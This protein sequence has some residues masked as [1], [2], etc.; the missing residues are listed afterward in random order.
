MFNLKLSASQKPFEVSK[1]SSLV[2]ATFGIRDNT[3]IPITVPENEAAFIHWFATVRPQTDYVNNGRMHCFEGAFR[4]LNDTYH[5]CQRYFNTTEERFHELLRDL[6]RSKS[7]AIFY[8]FDIKRFTILG[9]AYYYHKNE[10]FH[11]YPVVDGLVDLD[12]SGA[13]AKREQEINNFREY[14]K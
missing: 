1:T 14:C 8:C 10:C 11:G 6:I 2:K 12:G 9:G 7:I 3:A 13:P 5:L 4:S